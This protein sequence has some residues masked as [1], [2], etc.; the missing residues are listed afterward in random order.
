MN[1]IDFPTMHDLLELRR[2]HYKM[3]ACYPKVVSINSG[4]AYSLAGEM[5]N[6]HDFKVLKHLNITQD[7]AYKQL[8]SGQ[9][10][11]YGM[12]I[13]VVKDTSPVVCF[14]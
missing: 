9:V 11:I 8:L 4:L 2:Y 1:Q 6:F 14:L 7:E 12:E 10:R 5:A 13:D 3:T